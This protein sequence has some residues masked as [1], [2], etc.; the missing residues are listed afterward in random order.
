MYHHKT[1]FQVINNQAT[2]LLPFTELK[3]LSTVLLSGG[4]LYSVLLKDLINLA[5]NEMPC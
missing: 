2:D 5:V 4:A 3:V 1:A